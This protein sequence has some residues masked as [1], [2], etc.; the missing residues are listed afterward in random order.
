MMT[1]VGISW[2]RVTIHLGVFLIHTRA[3]LSVRRKNLG[4]DRDAF[5]RSV[6]GSRP[7][8]TTKSIVVVGKQS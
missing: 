3:N 2:E 1:A 4:K 8:G 6:L 7:C 5:G